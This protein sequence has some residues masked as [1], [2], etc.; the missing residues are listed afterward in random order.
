MQSEVIQGIL[1][2][3]AS[4]K[5]QIVDSFDIES[6]TRNLRANAQKSPVSYL[7]QMACLRNP[8]LTNKGW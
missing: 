4:L 5:G 3:Q 6:Q 8:N 7:N 2:S 1:Y